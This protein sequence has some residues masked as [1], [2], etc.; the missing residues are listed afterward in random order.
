MQTKRWFAMLV[1]LAACGKSGSSSSNGRDAGA[2]KR[3]VAVEEL[4]QLKNDACQCK[5]AE[6]ANRVETAFGAACAR[7]GPAIARGHTGGDG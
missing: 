6:C 7:L 4:E 2:P 3:N 5:D 1:L